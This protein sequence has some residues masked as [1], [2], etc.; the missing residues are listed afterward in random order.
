MKAITITTDNIISLIDVKEN[1]YKLYEL[2]R[3]VIGGYMEHVYPPMLP[4]GY[5]MTVNEQGKLNGL[6]VN[7]IASF[8][9]KSFLHGDYIIGDVIIL[10]LGKFEGESDVVGL[11]D[12]EADELMNKLSLFEEDDDAKQVD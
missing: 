7:P 3:K 6:P 9:Y 12:A 8:L 10:K 1:G 4:E 2:I 11:S 5:V